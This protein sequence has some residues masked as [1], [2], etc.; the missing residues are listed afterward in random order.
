MGENILNPGIE[1]D[2]K[3]NHANLRGVK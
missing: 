3:K 2:I 1:Y